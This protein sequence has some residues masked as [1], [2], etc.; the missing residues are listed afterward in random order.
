MQLAAAIHALLNPDEEP[1]DGIWPREQLLQMDAQFSAALERAFASG[2]E[3]RESARREV[4]LPAS[5]GP[6]WSTP[7]CPAVASGLLRSAA[8]LVFVARG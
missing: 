8:E 6:R 4:K 1:L 2:A 5:A 3:S 7:L